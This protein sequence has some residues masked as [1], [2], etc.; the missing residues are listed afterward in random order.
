M[1]NS[2][3]LVLEQAVSV[4]EPMATTHPIHRTFRRR[5]N[6]CSSPFRIPCVV[7]AQAIEVEVTAMG[8]TTMTQSEVAGRLGEGSLP[9]SNTMTSRHLLPM[10]SSTSQLY[11]RPNDPALHLLLQV[12][13]VDILIQT[14]PKTKA[15]LVAI[16]QVRVQVPNHRK[17]MFKELVKRWPVGER[18]NNSSEVQA[19]YLAPRSS[20]GLGRA[21]LPLV[22]VPRG[23]AN[24]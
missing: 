6:L 2:T 13:S 4:V 15:S 11:H 14:L 5:L 24:E 20:L 8:I 21:G 7:E 16:L 22:D 12:D 23:A 3:P 9:S 18:E 10:K 19:L 17:G 1:D